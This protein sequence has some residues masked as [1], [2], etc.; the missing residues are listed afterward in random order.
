V[1]SRKRDIRSRLPIFNA[2]IEL[3]MIYRALLLSNFILFCRS[4]WYTKPGVLCQRLFIRISWITFLLRRISGVLES[5]GNSRYK[6]RAHR[7]KV[8]KGNTVCSYEIEYSDGYIEL[9]RL[10]GT[11]GEFLWSPA[12]ISAAKNIGFETNV[13]IWFSIN[14]WLRCYFKEIFI[15]IFDM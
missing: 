10:D 6:Y 8:S 4:H 7:W 1:A 14:S 5:N 3:K 12:R 13:S 2:I 9:N 11:R 15:R